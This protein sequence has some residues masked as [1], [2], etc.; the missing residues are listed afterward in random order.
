MTVKLKHTDGDKI[1]IHK[2]VYWMTTANLKGWVLNLFLKPIVSET[3]LKSTDSEF[4]AH[5]AG[6][7]KEK[8]CSPK[9]VLSRGVMHWTLVVDWCRTGMGGMTP[10][11]CTKY[12]SQPLSGQSIPIKILLSILTAASCWYFCCRWTVDFFSVRNGRFAVLGNIFQQ[13]RPIN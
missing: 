10:V 7:G 3:V 8:A 13:W 9:L 1:E 11:H 12:N 6:P 5:A 4:R 2:G